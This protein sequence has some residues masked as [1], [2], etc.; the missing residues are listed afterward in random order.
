MNTVTREGWTDREFLCA[1]SDCCIA[2]FISAI[3]L[4]ECID[5]ESPH[6][7]QLVID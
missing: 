3:F 6:M 2:E 5:N 7:L 4:L 1:V